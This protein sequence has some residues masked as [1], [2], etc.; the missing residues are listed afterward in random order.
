MS[1]LMQH[2]T[3]PPAPPSTLASH[4]IA[5]ALDAIVLE[6][7]SK[8]PADRPARA[9]ALL[10]RLEA[11]DLGLQWDQRSARAWWEAHEPALIASS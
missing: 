6:C 5:P 2:S 11:L 7:L 1:I 3:R 4:P 8:D 10:E 9:E